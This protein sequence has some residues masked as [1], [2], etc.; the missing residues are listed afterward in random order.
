MLG[1][2]IDLV[3]V[4]L[5]SHFLQICRNEKMNF[6]NNFTECLQNKREP[7]FNSKLGFD[8]N[9]K[10]CMLPRKNIFINE[11]MKSIKNVEQNIINT[12]KVLD[13]EGSLRDLEK[14]GFKIK[15]QSMSHSNAEERNKEE[16]EEAL[17]LIDPD[18]YYNKILNDE[19]ISRNLPVKKPV[20]N[21][22]KDYDESA[23]NN[24]FI[25]PFEE[26][27]LKIDNYILLAQANPL[28]NISFEGT[29]INE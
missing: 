7:L 5:G 10:L 28:R 21:F 27:Q 11:I 29:L 1:N 14:Y 23:L 20:L 9:D 15:N 19:V 25:V 24:K 2:F 6:L 4:F 8:D 17:K 13:F 3:G 18:A 22:Q 26:K 16:S 12:S